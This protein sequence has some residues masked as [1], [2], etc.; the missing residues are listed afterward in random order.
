M[1]V[2]ASATARGYVRDH[3]GCLYVSTRRARCCADVV[4][5]L[6]AT[7]KAPRSLDGYESLGLDDINVMFRSGS[8]LP[9]EIVIELKGWPRKHPRAFWNG[10]AYAI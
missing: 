5:Y 6:D 4:T 3:G 7:T 10:C 8:R 1:R 9:Q 2:V